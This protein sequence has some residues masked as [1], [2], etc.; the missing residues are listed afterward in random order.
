VAA[1]IEDGRAVCTFENPAP[2]QYGV[3]AL[4]DLDEDGEM[5]KR[6]G[7]PREQATLK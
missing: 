2:G 3:A 7:I 6:M 5:D 4:H 1:P